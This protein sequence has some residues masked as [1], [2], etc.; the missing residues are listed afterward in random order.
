MAA[1]GG[2]DG[3][4]PGGV[5]TKLSPWSVADTVARLG[6]VLAAR[7]IKLFAIVD[8]SG[9]AHASGLELRDTKLVIFGN[10]Q[11]GTP[12]MNDAPLAALDLPLKILVWADGL[13]TKVSYTCPNELVV[14]YGV[15]QEIVAPLSGAIDAVVAA[16]IDR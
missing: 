6:A 11:A 12:V 15:P 1:P 5:V 14:R 9:E 4:G 10:P 3:A 2:T 13:A 7:G 16:T 8:H